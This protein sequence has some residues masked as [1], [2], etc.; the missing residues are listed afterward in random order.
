MCSFVF[1]AP[2]ERS[3]IRYSILLYY[4]YSKLIYSVDFLFPERLAVFIVDVPCVGNSN[5]AETP[6]SNSIVSV[7]STPSIFCG[8]TTLQQV[9]LAVKGCGTGQFA[10]I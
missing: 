2:R 6:L 8:Q 4:T 3:R 10:N 9:E 1:R 5:F 7:D